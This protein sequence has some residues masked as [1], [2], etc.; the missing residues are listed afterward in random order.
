MRVVLPLIIVLLAGCSG[1]SDAPD[2]DARGIDVPQLLSLLPL[3]I[4]PHKSPKSSS[5]WSAS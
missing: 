4:S 5:G 3:P 1:G 2:G